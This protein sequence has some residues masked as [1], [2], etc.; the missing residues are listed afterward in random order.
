MFARLEHASRKTPKQKRQRLFLNFSTWKGNRNHKDQPDGRIIA[1]LFRRC[2]KVCHSRRVPF[3]DF[4]NLNDRLRANSIQEK[5]T[6]LWL[7]R[8]LGKM[9]RN[10]HF[11]CEVLLNEVVRNH[12]PTVLFARQADKLR[13]KWPLIKIA[14]EAKRG[15]RV[16]RFR[17]QR[18]HDR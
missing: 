8:A 13:P 14:F 5:Q 7:E 17:R 12:P 4:K 3:L 2:G 6:N 18:F 1:F 11:A 9:L 16:S 10:N 15:G